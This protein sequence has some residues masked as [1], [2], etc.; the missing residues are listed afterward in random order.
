MQEYSDNGVRLG[1]LLD[2]Q[3]P[4]AKVYRLGQSVQTLFSPAALS[5]EEVL[6]GFVLDVSRVFG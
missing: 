6:P 3:T 5:G 1:W 2:P 4:Q